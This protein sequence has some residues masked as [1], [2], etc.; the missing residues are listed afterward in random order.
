MAGHQGRYDPPEG[1]Q[2]CL[3]IHLPH[4]GVPHRSVTRLQVATGLQPQTHPAVQ[5]ETDL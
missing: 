1:V 5:D 2:P 4:G 3:L